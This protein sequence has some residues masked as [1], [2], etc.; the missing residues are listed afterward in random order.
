MDLWIVSPDPAAPVSSARK[1]SETQMQ[2][3]RDGTLFVIK[4]GSP[5]FARSLAE[6]LRS[7]SIQL[8]G[9]DN[10]QL[11]HHGLYRRQARPA[12]ATREFPVYEAV[13][14]WPK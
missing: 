14:F 7:L 3:A 4:A 2:A 13:L 5:V 11:E 10:S 8:P 6:S 12:G 9:M 1:L